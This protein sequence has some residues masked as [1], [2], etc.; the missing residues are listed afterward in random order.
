MKTKLLSYSRQIMILGLV[1]LG[2][3]LPWIQ[4]V[5]AQII[6]PRGFAVAIDDMGWN[7]GGSLGES[8]GPYRLG[9]RRKFDIRDYQA[10]VDVGKALGVRLQALF[11]LSEMDRKNVCATYPTTTPAGGKFD[12]FPNISHLQLQIMKFVEENSA[13]LEFGLH[14]VGH[15]YWVNG[16]RTRAEWYDQENNQPRSIKDMRDHLTCFSAIMSQYGWSPRK[17]HSFPESFV[18]CSHAYYWNP[19]GASSTGQLM[20]ERGVKYIN[21]NFDFIPELHPPLKE[22]GGFDHGT[23]VIDRKAYGNEWYE[24]GVV[25]IIKGN[26]LKTDII[27]SHWVNWLATDD[28]LQPAVKKKWILF[29]R[30]IQARADRYLAKNTEQLFSQW[31][32]QRY[33]KVNEPFRG[34]QCSP[35]VGE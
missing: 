11:V 2:G 14:G 27:E 35:S 7:E 24:P 15:E 26:S 28:F 34:R 1:A 21:F 8:G 12:N 16:K 9:F 18:P 13:F 5:A 25:P 3:E 20:R 10:I 17:G 31:L 32:Y 19:Q 30:S 4:I 22:G 33:T 23:L 6:F 29:F